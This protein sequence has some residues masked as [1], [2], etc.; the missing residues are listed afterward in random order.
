MTKYPIGNYM[1]SH[2][3][4]IAYAFTANQFSSVSIPSSE[5][6]ALAYPEWKKAMNKEMKALQ[7]NASKT[8]AITQKKKDGCM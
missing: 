7:K 6:D 5:Q 1:S 4:S 2:R 3:L 8:C